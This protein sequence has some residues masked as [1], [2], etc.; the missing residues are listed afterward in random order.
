MKREELSKLL[1]QLNLSEFDPL[2]LILIEE[3]EKLRDKETIKSTKIFERSNIIVKNSHTLLE[4]RGKGFIHEL[5]LISTSPNFRI[6]LRADGQLFDWTYSELLELSPYL[7]TITAI[8]T[9]SKY[10]FRINSISFNDFFLFRI[11]GNIT[12]T[13]AYVKYDIHKQY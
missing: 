4:L 7:D 13:K 10:I 3:L 5:L 11:F 6:H 8:Q 9:N 12:I 1:T 2:Q